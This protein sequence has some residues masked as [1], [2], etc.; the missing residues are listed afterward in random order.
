MQTGPTH[1]AITKVWK[2]EAARVVGGL[3]RL[4]GD[5]SLAEELAQDVLV[6]ALEQWPKSGVPQN[7][8]AWL[9]T[10]AKHRALNVVRRGKMAERADEQLAHALPAHVSREALEAALEARM[11]ETVTDDS[12]R[13]FFAACHPVL[14]REAR[15]ALTL[16]MVGGLTTEEIARAFL[17]NEPAIAQRIVRAKR[18]LAEAQVPF[19]VPRGEELSDRLA[20]VLEVVYL[21]FNEGYSASSGDAL[22]RPA[23]VDDA[24]RLGRLLAALAPR[25]PEA[26]G[27]SALMLLQTSRAA[28]RTDANGDPV[29]LEEQD[30]ATWDRGLIVEGL[31]A[32]GHADLLAARRGPYHLQATLAA[33]HARAQT[34]AETDWA[35]IA[36]LYGELH[37]LNPS[38]V[39]ALN[40]ALAVSRAE[41]PAAGLALLDRL[42]GDARLAGYHFLPAARAELLERLGRVDEARAEFLRA[43]A[44]AGNERQ[45]ARLEQRAATAGRAR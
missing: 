24:L 2:S 42:A 23:L 20:S 22:V 15:V 28:A 36:A 10:A 38:P 6:T 44:L 17:S 29:L 40:R 4:L 5:V 21:V 12:L 33:C 30:R 9:M 31:V 25:E 14:P 7:P 35:Q 16:R 18:A 32:L 43:A 26:H 3:A 8:G 11:D 34:A 41:G 37:A 27:L 45:R 1:E 13:L 39:I 19:E